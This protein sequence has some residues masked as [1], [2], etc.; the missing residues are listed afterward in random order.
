ML[1]MVRKLA[2]SIRDSMRD[3]LLTPLFIIGE[4][5]LEVII[6]Y[7]MSLMIDNSIDGGNMGLIVRYGLILIGLAVLS[8]V[9]GAAAGVTS[10]IVVGALSTLTFSFCG[11]SEPEKN[12]K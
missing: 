7:V 12:T 6:P 3:T 5:I 11:F 8:L 10:L 9:C 1:H 4:V 2:G